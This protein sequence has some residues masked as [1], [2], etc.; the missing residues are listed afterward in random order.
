MN[1][2][3]CSIPGENKH[4][5]GFAF[6]Q[7][8]TQVLGSPITDA[9]HHGSVSASPRVEKAVSMFWPLSALV[10]NVSS[11]SGKTDSSSRHSS[12]RSTLFAN[13]MAGTG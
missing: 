6:E 5:V 12:V 10:R 3:D 9:C 1:R 4:G 11:D 2:K 8:L 7:F 13:K